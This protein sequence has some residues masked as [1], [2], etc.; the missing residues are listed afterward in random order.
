MSD[1]TAPTTEQ[2][3]PT[4]EEWEIPLHEI[5]EVVNKVLLPATEKIPNSV[6]F[7]ALLAL[8][9]KLVRPHLNGQELTDKLTDVV[10]F[11]P[12]VLEMPAREHKNETV[13]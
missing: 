10:E 8:A 4:S 11:L 3:E 6:A 13:H 1:E 7:F 12:K 5:S 2:T 9:V